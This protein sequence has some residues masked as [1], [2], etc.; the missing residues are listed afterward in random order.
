MIFCDAD[1]AQELSRMA[2]DIWIDHYTTFISKDE[3]EYILNMT[4]TEKAIRKQIRDGY[5]YSFIM[6]GPFKAGYFA[7]LLEGDSLFIS[8]YYVS[9]EYRGKGLGSKTMDEILEKGR[10]MKMKKA[11]LHVNKN[12]ARSIDIYKHKGFVIANAKKTDIGNGYFLDDYT[13]EYYF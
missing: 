5:L 6:D 3:I 1:D 9:K 10:A 12:N 2:W 13:M 11:Y 4:Q 7:M 8:K